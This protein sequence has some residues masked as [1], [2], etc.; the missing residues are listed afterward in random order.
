M[1]DFF[2]AG[3][4]SPRGK[5]PKSNLP[6][7]ILQRCFL[8]TL[9]FLYLVLLACPCPAE[10]KAELRELRSGW[11]PD[12]PYQMQA[13]PGAANELSGLDIQLSKEL[14]EQAGYRVLF[15]PMPWSE[16]LKGLQTGETDFLMGAYYEKSREEFAYYSRPYRTERNDIYYHE[17]LGSLDNIESVPDV[18]D[19][20][21]REKLNL[22]VID[23]HAYGSEK[24]ARLVRDPPPNL[25]LV[26]TQ[27]YRES[28]T[29][30][31][32]GVVD[33]FPANPIIMDRLIAEAENTSA[34]RKLGI[35][36]RKIPV[37]IL[38]SKKSIS[39]KQLKEFN[40]LLQ[41]MQDKG[42]INDLRREFVL[43]AY[44]S[45]TTGQTWFTVLNLLG[46]VAFC[47]SALFLARK[48]RYNLFGALVLATLPAIGGGVLRDLFLGVDQVFVLRTPA[49]FL[50]A[51][52]VVLA[53]FA[54]IKCYDFIHDRSSVLGRKID[55]FIEEKL[56]GVLGRLFKFFDAWA[57]ASFTV[58]GVGVALEMRVEP[59][60][61]WGPA[62]AV[63]TA[64]GG[65]ILRD[66]V[67]ADFNIEM[68]KQDTYAET[69][70]LGGIIYTW[71]LMNSS[72]ELSLAFIFYLTLAMVLLLFGLRFFILWKGYMNPL[73]FGDV[74]TH[75]DTRLQQFASREPEL[76][77]IIS[78]YYTDD[79]RSRTAPVPRAGLE[80]AHNRFMYLAGELKDSL[81]H[82][83]AEPLSE[84]SI[85][86]YRQCNARL[87]IA[88][89]LENNLFAFLEQ[90]SG[91]GLQISGDGLELQQLMHESLRTLIDT[92]AMA[93]ESRDHMDFSMLEGLTSQYRQ[94]F[95]DLRNKYF[96]RQRESG[97]AH[98]E[99]VLQ[100]THKVERI[101]FLLSDYVRLRLDKKE[102]RAGNPSNRKAQQIHTLTDRSF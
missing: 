2:L 10:S 32:E 12:E 77:E 52:C 92:T 73:Q 38:F 45:I 36:S 3:T 18:L 78:G 93:V 6:I 14:F 74:Y 88:M 26:P 67:R 5:Q 9:A 46:I 62:M 4:L 41:K 39:R 34:V 87:E 98:L 86:A 23:G 13:G 59:L 76:F 29:L 22:A 30:M 96:V 44:L 90:R 63:L 65:V 27:S 72:Y 60:W 55:S 58:I 81:D 70:L 80:G 102:I 28:L 50:V 20:L 97:D 16:I 37:H 33:L 17:S 94:R 25:N 8:S 82:V 84:N 56:G 42:R 7:S 85:N 99:A 47:V 61:L 75:P 49:Y 83:V 89:S 19:F 66:I 43:P 68:L 64:S 95:D 101:I 31:L 100:S 35:K 79:E 11:Y 53:G 40:S 57:V 91:T 15:E 1:F 69:S 71:V 24:F 51:I 54:S 48:E 21:Q